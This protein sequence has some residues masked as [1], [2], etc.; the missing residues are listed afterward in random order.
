MISKEKQIEDHFINKLIDLKYTYR[1][2]IRDRNALERNFRT[3]FEALNRVHLTDSE[4]DRLLEEIIDADVF[5]S[6]KRLR[7]INTFMRED[8]TPLQYMLVNIKDWCKNDY[9]VINQLRINTNNSYHRYDVILLINGIPVIQVELKASDVS[10]RRAMQQIVDYKN[11]TGNG[12]TNTLLCFMQL[13]IVSNQ[14]NTYYFT[15]NNDQHFSFNTDEQFLPV[16]QYATESNRKITH[17]DAFST[18]FL[19]KCTL[20][21]MINRYMVLVVSEQKL[22]IMR[23]Y[24]IYAVKAIID[25]IH[26]NRG[27]GYIWHTTGSGK[28]LTSFKASTLLKDNP[29]IDKCLFVVDRKDL[30][31]QTR[32]E[33]NKFQENCVEENTNTGTLVKRMLSDDY[34][35]K[36]IV[37]TIQK[38]GIALDSSN[39]NNYKDRLI[40]LKDKRIVFIFDECHR[41]QFGDNHKAIKEFFPNSQLFGFTGT[42]IFEQNATYTQIS[43]EEAS[44]K[45]TEDIFPSR[46]H[47]YTITHAIEDKNVLR[48]HV[49]YFKPKETGD[50][51]A[52]GTLKKQAVVD[53]ILSKHDA[54]THSR[55]FNAILA[56]ASIN[57]AIEYYGLFRR[58][59]ESLMQQN[60]NYEPLNIACVFSPPA[61]GN[62]DIQQIQEDLPQEQND[63]CKEPEEKKKALK[64]IIDD[65]NRQYKTNHTIAEFDAYYQDVQ[66]RIKDQQYSNKDYPHKNKIDITIV[67]DMLLTGFDSKYLNTLYVDKNLK[68]HGLIQA[69]SRTNRILNDTKPYG[70]ILDFRG[71]QDAVD[72]AIALFSGEKT[73]NPKEIWLVDSAPKVIEK[74]QDAVQKLSEYMQ[75]QG[76]ECQAEN[77]YSL[78]GDEARAGF[79]NC[80]KEVQRYRTQLEQYTDINEQE[81]AKI[82]ELLPEETLRSFRGAYIETAQQLRKQRETGKDHEVSPQVEDL[83]FEFVLFASAVI[84]YDY[85]MGLIARYTNSKNSKQRVTKEQLISLVASSAN[86]IDERDDIREYIDSLDEVNGKTE[87]EIKEGYEAFKAEKYAKQLASIA[88]K[89]GITADSLRKFVE[90]IMERMIFDGEKLSDLLA[91][92]ELGWKART[93]AELALMDDL[94]PLLKR[95]AAGREIS[96]LSAYED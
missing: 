14:A 20:G 16:Y 57:E 77:V 82:E 73:D 83:D 89:H 28:T 54:A 85:I 10:P 40:H 50:R 81:K 23:P 24:Q 84:D 95:L 87:Q 65:Y 44:Y 3:K 47:A 22:L 80:F 94:V 46:L 29:D 66:K 11:D 43:G 6:S 33:F 30:D 32:E 42:P 49:D 64:T 67:V 37:T 26:Q 34:A 62:K 8:G 5:A 53:A 4:F 48:F 31:R 19:S 90:Q 25:C 56:T 2:D 71:Q 35:D 17:L 9:E 61:E 72:E 60:E 39:K 79:I 68:Y 88:D 27:N 1:D 92:L 38:L 13:F 15:N 55:R 7:G 86:L 75:S 52:D 58:A 59:Q 78:Q 76:L 12:Y 36:V 69:F 91:P 41:S 45:I 18:A 51:R 93:K 96:G 74:F 70:N 21:E 63:N